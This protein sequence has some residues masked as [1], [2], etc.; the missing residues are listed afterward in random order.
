MKRPVITRV[1][2]IK[3]VGMCTHYQ[4]D[5]WHQVACKASSLKGW[6]KNSH[7]VNP[8]MHITVF[9][10]ANT[11]CMQ[12]QNWKIFVYRPPKKK[13]VV[14][15][16]H[17]LQNKG[18][19]VFSSVAAHFSCAFTDPSR[20]SKFHLCIQHILWRAK[21]LP[22]CICLAVTWS[23]RARECVQFA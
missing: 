3:H 1:L 23:I 18:L 19:K 14:T 5:E 10:N 7:P 12:H 22:S 2:K 11:T 6:Y 20:T 13:A 8:M 17:A 21:T 16:Y 15:M 4:S 9:L